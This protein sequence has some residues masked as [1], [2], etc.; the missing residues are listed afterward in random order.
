MQAVS[1]RNRTQLPARLIPAVEIPSPAVS[2]EDSPGHP[3]VFLT[4]CA[5]CGGQ[6]PTFRAICDECEDRAEA[7][8]F[9]DGKK[10]VAHVPA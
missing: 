1:P 6:F 9:R 10:V 4:E 5:S 8:G 3:E 7:D 2:D